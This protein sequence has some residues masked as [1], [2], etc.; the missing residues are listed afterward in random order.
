M[1]TKENKQQQLNS[2]KKVFMATKVITKK[3]TSEKKNVVRMN[4]LE[5][6]IKRS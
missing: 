5:K 1:V 2:V 3:N 6:N 4:L